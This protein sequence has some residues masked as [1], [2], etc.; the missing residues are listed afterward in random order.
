MEAEKKKKD[1]LKSSRNISFILE[2][3]VSVNWMLIFSALVVMVSIAGMFHAVKNKKTKMGWIL[4][5]VAGLYGAFVF[6]IKYTG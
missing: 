1:K 4:M 2:R 5:L 6:S 3:G